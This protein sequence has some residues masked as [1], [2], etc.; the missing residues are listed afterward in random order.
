VPSESHKQQN[1]MRLVL[2][3]KHGHRAALQ[4]LSKE[5]V[6]SIK[7]AAGSM[8]DK[9]IEDFAKGPLKKKG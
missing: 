4:G 5:T 3:Y 2:A 7:E 9:Q 8:S 6:S 1:F